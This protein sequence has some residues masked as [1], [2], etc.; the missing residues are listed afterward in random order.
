M[1]S[2]S[3]HISEII[4]GLYLG[5]LYIANDIDVL[6]NLGITKVLSLIE[7]FRIP[8]YKESDNIKHK[9]ILIDDSIQQNIIKYF[10]ECLNFIKGEENILVHCAAGSSRSA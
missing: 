6:K 10:G 4:K 8:K 3:I 5:N 7:R 2:N 9:V 1:D